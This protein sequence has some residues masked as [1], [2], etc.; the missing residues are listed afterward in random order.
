MGFYYRN[1]A[2]KLPQ[3]LLTRVGPERQPVQPDL[4]RQHPPVR[5]QPREEHRRRQHRRRALVPPQHAAE[6]PGAR[7]RARPARRRATPRARAAT[8][9][10]AWSTRVGI[11]PKTPLF[12][13]ATWARRADLVALVKV[14]QRRE[15]VQRR[16]LRA[17]RRQGQVG[18]L[19]DQ[20]LRRHRPRA[21]RRPGSRCSRAS[22]CR[23]RSPTRSASTATR[24]TSFGGNQG[25][26]NYSVGLGAD[27]QQKYRFDLKY[28]DF[29]GH[30]TR[31]R[32]RRDRR[33]NGLTTY[34]KDRGF[35]SLT[36]KT[37][38]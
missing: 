21:S 38:F 6:Q 1:F 36:F 34:L 23:R 15:P 10:T 2:D 13:S 37:T 4:R 31:Q 3:V 28:I 24:A 22:T 19:R 11:V 27:V 25:L 5:R 35:V 8:P 26:G 18:R 33:T 14:T 29:V 32:H 17:L 12:D 16:R 7:R 9:G 20:E 30:Y